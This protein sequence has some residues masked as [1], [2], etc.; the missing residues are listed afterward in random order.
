MD[1]IT[2]TLIGAGFARAL[3]KKFRRPEIYWACVIGNNI[4]DADFLY[5]FWPSTTALDYL[6]HH[7]GYTHTVLL[8]PILALGT[9]VLARWAGRARWSASLYLFAVLSGFLHI[10]AD[11]MNNYGV[12]PLTPFLNRWFYGDAVFIVEPLIWFSLIPWIAIQAERRW[13]KIGWA[14]LA[15]GMLTLVWVMPLFGMSHALILTA[16]LFVSALL[17]W[18]FRV[19]WV[20]AAL[21]TITVGGF[22][23]LSHRTEAI[24]E[25]KWSD[26]KA[27]IETLLDVSATP[28]PGNLFC[29]DVWIASK[30][31]QAFYFRSATV[32]PIPTLIPIES[33][34]AFRE[35]RTTASLS[36]IEFAPD[37]EL[38]WKKESVL[39]VNEWEALRR[40]NCT[41]RRFMS[42]ARFP[43]LALSA[44]GTRIAGD[45]RYDRESGIGIAEIIIPATEDCVPPEANEDYPWEEP[46]RR[47]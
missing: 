4:P 41:F 45:L 34:A 42:F 5:K 43:F 33:C 46:L 7:R 30:T 11:A 18:Q 28:S 24:A 37:P 3:P 16:L 6:L 27:E 22:F 21:F 26:Q 19:A 20:P 44:D 39:L 10:A 15:A 35:H 25:K 31:K 1:N 32:A 13:A 17:Q 9:A 12:H 2:H 14:F 40:T 36:P 38:K 23:V 47:Y 29:W 8:T